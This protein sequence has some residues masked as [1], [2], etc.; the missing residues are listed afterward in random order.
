MDDEEYQKGHRCVGAPV[1]DYRG[2]AVAAISA[3]GS[4]RQLP[5]SVLDSVISEVK[6]VAANLSR[7]M[8]Y[9]E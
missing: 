5:D 2:T 7:R 1:F 4:I 3:S 8:G 6:Q 9:M